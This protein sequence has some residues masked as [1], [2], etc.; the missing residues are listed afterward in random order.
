MDQAG[1]LAL[2]GVFL[3]LVIS[4]IKTLYSTATGKPLE[5]AGAYWLTFG[6]SFVMAAV[7]LYFTDA[8]G[9]APS[10][11]LAFAE[12]LALAYTLVAGAAGTIY[13]VLISKETGLASAFVSRGK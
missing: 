8:L 1:Y 5:G 9:T 12:W 4:L 7:I 13:R 11:P 3:G 10:D 6:L 2:A